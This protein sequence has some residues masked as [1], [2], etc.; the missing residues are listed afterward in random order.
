MKYLPILLA[1]LLVGCGDRAEPRPLSLN[2]FPRT[3]EHVDKRV[4]DL[5]RLQASYNFS[6][7]PDELDDEDRQTNATLRSLIWYY[8]LEC[9]A[10]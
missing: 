4:A 3:C 1:I 9:G 8:R 5:K 10:Q 2:D 7:D 6:D